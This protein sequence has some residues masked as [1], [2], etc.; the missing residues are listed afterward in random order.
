[1][2]NYEI[3]VLVEHSSGAVFE[4]KFIIQVIDSFIP[5]VRTVKIARLTSS[6][7]TLEEGYG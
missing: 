4:K 6:G 7:A 1:M 2:P 3:T 5:I